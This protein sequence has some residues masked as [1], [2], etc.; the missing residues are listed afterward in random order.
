MTKIIDSNNEQVKEKLE[1]KRLKRM[2]SNRLNNPIKDKRI[3]SLNKQK[4]IH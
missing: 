4:R 1:N 2:N 3:T